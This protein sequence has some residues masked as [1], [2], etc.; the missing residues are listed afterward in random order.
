M[1]GN[2][3]EEYAESPISYD[4]IGLPQNVSFNIQ[5]PINACYE[6]YAPKNSFKYVE[7][8]LKKNIGNPQ[9]QLETSIFLFS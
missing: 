8:K 9:L 5:N 3:I 1:L 4:Q 6:K 7:L 2:G